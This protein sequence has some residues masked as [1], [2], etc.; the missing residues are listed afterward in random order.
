MFKYN[1]CQVFLNEVSKQ[2][3]YQWALLSVIDVY[4][5]NFKLRLTKNMQTP[6]NNY[7]K[8]VTMYD[9]SRLFAVS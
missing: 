2:V 7:K 9:K 1:A 5:I 4:C 8:I 3:L 6:A